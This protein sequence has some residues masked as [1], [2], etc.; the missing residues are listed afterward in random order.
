MRRLS[1]TEVSLL[2]WLRDQGGTCALSEN[3]ECA[4]YYRLVKIGYVEMRL[5]DRFNPTVVNFNLTE[6]GQGILEVTESQQ[7]VC[8]S[9]RHPNPSSGLP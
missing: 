8:S 7:S 2:R 3:G 5:P 4:K 9:R 1:K 6:S